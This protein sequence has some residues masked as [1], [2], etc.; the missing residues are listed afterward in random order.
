MK[1]AKISEVADNVIVI[2]QEQIRNR[3]YFT[4]EDAL[5]DLPGFQFRNIQ[6]FNSYIFQR[7]VTNQNNYILL[8]VDDIQINE[9]N[10]GGF[11][12]GGQFNLDKEQFDNNVGLD[13]ATAKI[14]MDL[15]SGEMEIGN[16][17]EKGAFVKLVFPNN[18]D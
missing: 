11:Y 6:G 16:N 10:S 5:A 15:H 7:G 4:L 8:L 3:G 2:S 18:R 12:T 17:K 13:L 14:I 1:G 9:L